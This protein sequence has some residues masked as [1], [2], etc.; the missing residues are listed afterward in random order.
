MVE[1][2]CSGAVLFSFSDIGA[3]VSPF[4]NAFPAIALDI[5]SPTGLSLGG[6]GQGTRII[7]NTFTFQ[8]SLFYQAGRH[9]FR[10]GAGVIREQVSNRYHS[11]GGEAFLSW[12][13]FL[14]GLDAQGNGT[15]PF[16]SDGLASSN[17]FF[18][19]DAPGLFGRA[20]RVWETNAYIQDD[21]K[22]NARLTLNL[23]FRFDRLG[24]ISDAL[25]RNGSLDSSLLDRNPPASGTLAGYVVPSNYSGGSIPPGVTQSGNEFAVKGDAQ[26]TWN[27]RMGLAWQLPHTNRMVL[28]SGYGVY[29]SRYTGQPFVQLLG[30]PPFAQNRFFIFGNN[31]A[32]TEDVPFPLD[33]VTLPSFP[34]YSPFTA[35][36]TTT[37]DPHFRAPVMQQYSLGIQTQLPG[38]IVLEVGYSGACGLHLIRVRSINQA[39]IASPANPIR[40]ETTNTLA[41]VMLRVPFQGWDPA[42]LQQIESA[43]ASWYN[44]LL[45]SLNKRFSHGLQ[46]QISYTFSKN[47]TTDPLTSIN[48]NGGFSNGDQNNPKLRYGPDFFVREHRLIANFTYQFPGPKDLSSLRGQLLGGWHVAG[49]TTFQ[50]GNHLLVIF[51]PNGLNVSG[52]PLIA[53]PSPGF[54]PRATILIPDQ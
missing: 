24:D 21:F 4:D 18:S 42:N 44:A 43:G 13:D 1:F 7:Q 29:H 17:I 53:L 52:K 9:S 41:N 34:A 27:P 50:S 47:S 16:A 20:Y 22:L 30:T 2:L 39:G 32:A 49:V 15:A 37:F 19:V 54:A 11:F 8:D 46:A 38:D 12:P 48:G 28:R 14:L 23:G 5:G 45:A 25:G 35:L 36:T 3:T 26:N 40:G 6:N 10:L 31:A 51:S 33:P